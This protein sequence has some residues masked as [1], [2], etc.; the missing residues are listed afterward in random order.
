MQGWFNIQK[1]ISVI[2]HIKR[3]K[4][5]THM[6]ISIEA[7]K[8][9]DKIQQQFMGGKSLSKL[10]IERNFLNLTKNIYKK[11]IDN[12][13]PNDVTF[14]AF[15]LK[16]VSMQGCSLSTLLFNIVLEVIAN[17]TRE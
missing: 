6:I 5:N 17:I 4:E 1:S 9:S 8:A 11:P 16:S 12:I 14:E 3:L 10:G 13:I 2:Y 7:E 15:P